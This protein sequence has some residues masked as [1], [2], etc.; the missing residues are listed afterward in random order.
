[1]RAAKAKTLN[2]PE[3]T[4]V[5]AIDRWLDGAAWE[6]A[7]WTMLSGRDPVRL[8]E[9]DGVLVNEGVPI[10]ARHPARLLDLPEGTRTV[11]PLEAR[12]LA[13]VAVRGD[14]GFYDA[15]PRKVRAERLP[16]RHLGWPPPRAHQALL[17]AIELG[18][19]VGA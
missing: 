1:M 4:F 10:V 16:E 18:R 9:R 5:Q 7:D 19:Q 8:Q 11:R 13:A 14:A 3:R 12:A 2:V 15:E 17:D 6:G